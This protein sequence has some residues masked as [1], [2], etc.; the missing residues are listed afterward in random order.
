[1]LS[2]IFV[3]SVLVAQV[4]AT[5]TQL[6]YKKG[7]TFKFTL[8]GVVDARG[9]DQSTN[10]RTSGSFATL[11]STLITQCVDEDHES[12]TFVMNL[13]GTKVN[14]GQGDTVVQPPQDIVNIGDDPLGYDMYYQQK[15]S[16]EVEKIWYN[17]EDSI[18]FI[19]VKTGAINAF[20]THLLNPGDTTTLLDSDPVGIHYSTFQGDDGDQPNSLK[21]NKTF[22]ALDVQAFADKH[23]KPGNVKI[24][25]LT[26]TGIHAAGYIESGSVDQL[27]DLSM[28]LLN[29]TRRQRT[30][31]DPS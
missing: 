19:N 17:V 3:L 25:A 12:Y 26:N 5:P 30:S 31:M 22:N 1:M 4:C 2:L 28:S 10:Q 23:L 29:S 8:H 20:H 14:V 6:V 24:V 13:F 16:G 11:D 27:V 7:Q 9:H 18:Y 21:V 15:K